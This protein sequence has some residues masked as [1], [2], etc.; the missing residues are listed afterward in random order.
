[1]AWCTGGTNASASMRIMWTYNLYQGRAID[2]TRKYIYVFEYIYT[3]RGFVTLFIEPPSY[4]ILIVN[5]NH[6]KSEVLPAVT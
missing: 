3:M 1:M 5:S 4:I 6:V 2:Y